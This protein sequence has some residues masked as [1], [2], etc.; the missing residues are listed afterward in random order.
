MYLNEVYLEQ[1]GNEQMRGFPLESLYC[2][3]K[4]IDELNLDQYALLVGVVK[5]AYLYNL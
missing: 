4:P 2:F 5:G 3:G 1:D